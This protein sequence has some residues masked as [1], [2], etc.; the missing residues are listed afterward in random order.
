MVNKMNKNKI[1]IIGIF[2]MAFLSF[3]PTVK[4]A[5]PITAF[6]ECAYNF[7]KGSNKMTSDYMSGSNMSFY[8]TEVSFKKDSTT[9]RL[10]VKDNEYSTY[11]DVSGLGSAKGYGLSSTD[12]MDDLDNAQTT[13]KK[14]YEANGGNCPK[15]FLLKKSSDSDYLP[16]FTNDE[17]TT[18]C[19]SNNDN[20][21]SVGQLSGTGS[22]V[23]V[24]PSEQTWNF[25]TAGEGSCDEANV[26]IKIDSTGKLKADI[27]YPKS[28]TFYEDS[29]QKTVT[30]SVDFGYSDCPMEDANCQLNYIKNLVKKGT[31][32]KGFVRGNDGDEKVNFN[33][34][35]FSKYSCDLLANKS[36]T[37]TYSCAKYDSVKSTVIAKKDTALASAK[38]IDD[39]ATKYLYFNRHSDTYTSKSY[40]TVTDATTLYNT[41]TEINKAIK[42]STFAATSSSYMDYLNGLVTGQTL[43]TEDTE[44]IKS[45][46]S[47]YADLAAKEA[48]KVTVLKET[49][50]KIK[51]RLTALGETEKAEEVAGYIDTANGVATDITSVSAKART[52]MLASQKF[53]IKAYDSNNPCG[54]VS[55]D[56]K[57]FLQTIIDYIRIAGIA[58]AVIL[59]ILDYIKVIF[60]SDE[61]SMAKANKNFS[62]RLIAVALLFLIPAV[63]TFVLGLFNILGTGSAGTCGIK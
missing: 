54:V 25:S 15:I 8:F 32:K 42:D 36:T 20:C 6:G 49:L 46:L 35:A 24:Y 33:D 57:E 1:A 18:Y 53:G 10:F 2:I 44:Q 51:D 63:L 22:T 58:L 47:T 38:G 50:T 7:T 31:I 14:A 26:I 41:A 28:S 62:T 40:S 37:P 4:A 34:G 55:T 3:S 11:E 48:A 59:G 12:S 13:F 60:G 39:I 19:G 52:S 43:C 27:S 30:V 5:S 45:I 29:A 23:K 17:S 9:G 16:Y 61:K 56:L 21:L